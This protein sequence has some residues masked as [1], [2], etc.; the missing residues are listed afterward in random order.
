MLNLDHIALTVRDLDKSIAFYIKLGYKLSKRFSDDEYEWATLTHV[1]HSLELFQVEDVSFN[2]IAYSY[3]DIQEAMELVK[4]L[5]CQESELDIFYGNLNRES[6][7]IKD[8]NGRS[9]QL[10]KK[11][12][13]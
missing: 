6:F 8:N 1:S 3:D 2:H 13:D 4:D 12:V 11:Q 7:F 5:G 10:I 9:I